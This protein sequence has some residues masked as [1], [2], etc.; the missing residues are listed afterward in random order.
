MRLK[1]IEFYYQTHPSKGVHVKIMKAYNLSK[2]ILC[3]KFFDYNL[4]KISRTNILE[5]STGQII[6]I[7]VLMT[8]LRLKLQM[9][10]I[11]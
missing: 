9:Q 4:H 6:W 2:N 11:N 1:K 8:D 3:H 5:N 7:V 10:L